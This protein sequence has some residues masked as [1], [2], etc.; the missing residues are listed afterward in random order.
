MFSRLEMSEDES[1]EAKRPKLEAEKGGKE[2]E[3][4]DDDDGWVGPM[5]S[6]AAPTKNEKV[7]EFE[8]LYLKSLPSSKNYE[9]SYMHREPVWINSRNFSVQS[10]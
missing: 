8:Q 3:D 1:S 6:E 2:D 5:P 7:L 4:E 10:M 9:R